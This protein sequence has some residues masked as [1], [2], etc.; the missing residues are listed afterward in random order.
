M[1]LTLHSRSFVL[2]GGL[3]PPRLFPPRGAEA[4]AVVPPRRTPLAPSR[5][6]AA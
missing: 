6:A 3:V 1:R 4:S 5:L 2:G